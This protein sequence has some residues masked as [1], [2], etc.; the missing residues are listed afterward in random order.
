[1]E[2]ND[3]FTFGERRIRNKS[4]IEPV[5]TLCRKIKSVAPARSGSTIP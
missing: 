1:M 3:R 2:A 4:A 5:Y